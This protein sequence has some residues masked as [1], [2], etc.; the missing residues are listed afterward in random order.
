[1]DG[2]ERGYWDAMMNKG[3][4]LI[5]REPL[6]T[7]GLSLLLPSEGLPLLNLLSFVLEDRVA[8]FLP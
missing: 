4:S 8:V 3:L 6:N 2:L 5:H 7:G 1:M